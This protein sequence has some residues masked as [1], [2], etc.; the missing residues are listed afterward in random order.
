MYN[1]SNYNLPF[2]S[3]FVSPFGCQIIHNVEMPS[4]PN[5]YASWLCY[6]GLCRTGFRIK[7]LLLLNLPIAN[8]CTRIK[9]YIS[10]SRVGGGNSSPKD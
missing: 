4:T 7:L 2:S 3:E 8:M 10:I 9:Y 5:S 1:V 6:V